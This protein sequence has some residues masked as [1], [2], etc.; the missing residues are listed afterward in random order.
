MDS[1]A[2]SDTYLRAK[3]YLTFFAA[4]LLLASLV[5][6][7]PA[8]QSSMLG[9]QIANPGLAGIALYC[10]VLYYF[11]QLALFWNAQGTSIRAL[12][13]HTFDYWLSFSIAVAALYSLPTIMVLQTLGA[14]WFTNRSNPTAS[15]LIVTL[16]A[17]PILGALFYALYFRPK[18]RQSR[19]AAAQREADVLSVLTSQPWL[20]V[21][22][23][24][25][26][27]QTKRQHG[28]KDIVFLSD[29]Q[30]GKGRNHNEN[31]WRLNAGYL[32][33][34]DGNGRIF[35]RFTYDAMKERFI[36]TNDEDLQS[37]RNQYM[38]KKAER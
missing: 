25:S 22:N 1:T 13:Q 27:E 20:L 31:T 8:E 15:W 9:W 5:G 28:S 30:I 6:L 18:L 38:L 29:G 11:A 7:S 33:L 32:E 24:I 37:I 17:L 35:S 10:I 2:L 4:I 26:Y 21:F 34:L 12:A 14:P 3:R 23:P 36:H 19:D 16:Y